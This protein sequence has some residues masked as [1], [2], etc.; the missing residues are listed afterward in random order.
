MRLPGDEVKFVIVASGPITIFEVEELRPQAIQMAKEGP[1]VPV[2]M[3]CGDPVKD[4][5]TA[6]DMERIRDMIDQEIA[7]V[8]I[9]NKIAH[10]IRAGI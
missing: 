7:W 9:G 1:D 4:P 5:L 10:L 2:L 3:T 8:R 6:D